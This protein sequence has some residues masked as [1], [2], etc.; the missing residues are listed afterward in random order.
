[1]KSWDAPKVAAMDGDQRRPKL[2]IQQV[3]DHD[4]LTSYSRAGK[5]TGKKRSHG[6]P[7]PVNNS[8]AS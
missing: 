1:M 6:Q 8:I 4:S 7:A 3:S 5:P 2:D